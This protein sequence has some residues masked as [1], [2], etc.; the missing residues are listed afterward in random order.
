MLMASSSVFSL[1]Y[2]AEKTLWDNPFMVR[3]IG[4][5]FSVILVNMVNLG[6]GP[7]VK[8]GRINKIL[9]SNDPIL[10]MWGYQK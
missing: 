2:V 4:I 10:A 1:A 3:T 9:R 8:I 7:K 5:S 6:W